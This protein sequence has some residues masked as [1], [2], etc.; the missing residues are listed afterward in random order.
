MNLPDDFK[1]YTCRLLGTDGFNRLMEGL[2]QEAVISVRLNPT[3]A[4]SQ[5]LA[6]RS[7]PV[8]WCDGGHYLACRPA[9]TFDPLLHAGAYYVQEASSMFLEQAVLRYISGP[10]TALDLCAAPGGKSTHLRSILPEGSLLVSNEPIRARSQ[11]LAENMVKW[12]HP[13]CVVTNNYPADFAGLV[14]LFDVIVADVPCS[15]EG[16]FRK[17]QEAVANWTTDNV[18]LCWKRQRDILSSIWPTLKPGGMLIYSTCTFN[19][20]ENEENVA[21]IAGEL[22]A[23]VLPIDVP[24][25]W[26]ITG[27]LLAQ[28]HGDIVESEADKY[29]VY[30]FLPGTAQGEG[31]FMAVLRK[32]ETAAEEASEMTMGCDARNRNKNRNGRKSVQATTSVSATCKAWIRDENDFRFI[33]DGR[34]LTAFPT[35]FITQLDA[36]EKRLTVLYAGIKVAE[37]KGRDWVPAHALA[38]STQCRVESFASVQLTYGQAVAY[39]RAEAVVLPEGTPRGY[40][41]LTYRDV[42]LGFAKQVGNRANNLY[43]SEWRIRSGH[44]TPFSLWN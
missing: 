40:V 16:M 18:E 41:L 38:M 23:E 31:F 24:A 44:V 13:A 39:L 3:K 9:F 7:T 36:L 25:E 42:P 35:Q 22:G 5:E 11:V 26:G 43:P 32:R 29:P 28:G 1:T 4:L 20:F 10:V 33:S 34:V 19:A 8:P 17:D 30:H 37:Y 21:W 12:G 14:G 6:E 27:N 2:G 15:G